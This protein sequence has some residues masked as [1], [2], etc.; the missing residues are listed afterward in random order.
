MSKDDGGLSLPKTPSKARS[1][2][3][4]LSLAVNQL[5]PFALLTL[6]QLAV[7]ACSIIS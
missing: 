5:L 2:A 7:P 6:I 1:T 3:Q 4:V